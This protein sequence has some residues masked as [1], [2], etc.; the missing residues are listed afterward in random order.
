MKTTINTIL[1]TLLLPAVLSL[2]ACEKDDNTV[3]DADGNSYRT[4]KI[5]TQTW[6]AENLKTTTYNDGT[7]IFNITLREE[8]LYAVSKIDNDDGLFQGRIQISGKLSKPA[9]S[10]E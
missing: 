8:W 9:R 7:P 4:V 5:G 1:I 2:N 6:M 3:K 10:A